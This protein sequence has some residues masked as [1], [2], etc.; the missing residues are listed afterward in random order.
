[1]TPLLATLATV[2]AITFL[3]APLMG[4]GWFWDA[5][6]GM[7]FAAFAGLLYLAITS[8]R[9]L[10]VRAHQVLAYA[11]LLLVVAHAFW[12]LLGDATAVE[13]IKIGA[14]DYMWLGVIALLLFGIL[15][16]SADV[17]ERLR[18]HKDYAGFRYWHR[19]L[20]VVVILAAAYHIVGSNF[21]LG[22]WYQATLFALMSVAVCL[23][24]DYWIRLGEINIV[25]PVRFLVLSSGLA[26]AFA[27]IRNWPA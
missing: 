22:T 21:Y 11:V 27:A 17:P 25:S 12:F 23:G 1:M 13:F 5:G 10:D 26:I 2:F 15:I 19:V 24:R 6:N 14:P 7:G 9:R 20:T 3:G 16:V 18:L 4:A 8:N